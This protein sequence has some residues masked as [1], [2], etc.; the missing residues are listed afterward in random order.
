MLY[1]F[2]NPVHRSI[3]ANLGDIQFYMKH[4]FQLAGTF[5]QFERIASQLQETGVQAVIPPFQQVV[6]NGLDFFMNTVQCGFRDCCFFPGRGILPA[7]EQHLEHSFRRKLAV[8]SI[9]WLL[10][11]LA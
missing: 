10:G 11:T 4:F 9:K 8:A 2:R 1:E 7:A 5:H 6:E 3:Q